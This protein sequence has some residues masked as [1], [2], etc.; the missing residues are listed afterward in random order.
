MQEMPLQ[1][2]LWNVSNR[3]GKSHF[4]SGSFTYQ[5]LKIERLISLST[6]RGYGKMGSTFLSSKKKAFPNP[7]NKMLVGFLKEL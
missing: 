6:R 4:K 3:T 1:D 5:N 2:Y 7:E